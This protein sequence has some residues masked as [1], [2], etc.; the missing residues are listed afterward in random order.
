[1]RKTA[2]VQTLEESMELDRGERR[3]VL[4]EID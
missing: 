1:M 2:L 3:G 4:C